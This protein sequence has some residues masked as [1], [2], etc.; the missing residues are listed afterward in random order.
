VAPE[1]PSVLDRLLAEPERPEARADA[2]E[3][4]VDAAEAAGQPER[5]AELAYE[6]GELHERVL[7]DESSA[8]KAFGRALQA[9]P[10]LRAN[11]WAIRRVFYR[12]K[13]WPNLVKLVAA[14]A[15]ISDDPRVRAE[16]WAE[17][18]TVLEAH[19]GDDAEAREAFDL[20]IEADPTYQP[21]LLGRERIALRQ[22]DEGAQARVWDLLAE[23]TSLPARR[24]SYLL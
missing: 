7:G 16:R 22:G 15:R 5:A 24:L 20:A 23:A 2:L 6:L 18:A 12:R 10:T 19:L 4:E 8:V 13:L 3:R 17:R 21:A 11:L 14:E 9:D 1:E